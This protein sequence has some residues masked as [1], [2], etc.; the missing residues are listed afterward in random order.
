MELKRIWVRLYLKCLDDDRNH[1]TPASLQPC[2]VDNGLAT[3]YP[4]CHTFSSHPALAPLVDL[5]L[6][7]TLS[8]PHVLYHEWIVPKGMPP[9]PSNQ[10]QCQYPGERIVFLIHGGGYAKFSPRT[11]RCVA[12]H[13][14]KTCNL[15][16]LSADYRLAPEY[17]FPGGLMDVI[18]TYLALIDPTGTGSFQPADIIFCGD[19]AGGALAL[20]T[21]MYLRDN[22]LPLPRA[23]ALMSPWVNFYCDTPSYITN[24]PVDIIHPDFGNYPELSQTK[25]TGLALDD[26]R[27]LERCDHSYIHILEANLAGLPHILVQYGDADMLH[28]DF[29]IWIKR[30]AT[31]VPPIDYTVEEYPDMPHIFQLFA[32]IDVP[33]ASQAISKIGKFISEQF[34]SKPFNA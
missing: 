12:A 13:L 32:D 24:Q 14:A 1:Y 16:L 15:R 17:P 7:G 21:M 8:E 34:G 25:Y 26:S 20:A 31:T 30:L 27:F 4:L 5:D 29:P 28:D 23:A 2:P 3:A 22:N 11:H 18:S 33:S 6:T 9:P 19:S 10:L